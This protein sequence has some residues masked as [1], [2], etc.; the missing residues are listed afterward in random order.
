MSMVNSEDRRGP[1]SSLL[2]NNNVLGFLF[3][4]PAAVFLVCFLTYPLGLGVWLGFTDTRIGRDG[5]FIGLENYQFLMDDSVF[6][7]SVF[8]TILY[9]SV[10]SVLKFALG[11]W[12]AM[13]LNQHLPFKSFFRAIV[14]LPWVVPT[15]LSALAFW[16]IY[17]SQ[18]SIISWS[19]MKL[20]LISGPINFLG[21]PIN[22]RISV[23]VANVWRGIPFV[24]IS[25]LAGL[26]TIPASLQE[27]ASLDGATSWQ[28][29]RYVTLPMLTP[30]IAVV[31]TF[32]VLFT[33]T[34]FQLIYVL[35]KGGPVNATHLMATLSFQRGI[36]GGQL[37]EGA[38]IAVA[39]V[40]FLLGAIMFSFFG[41]QRRKWQQGGQD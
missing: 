7:L 37:G 17:D 5:I 41:L 39:M 34:D 21:D 40:P 15:V 16:W 3:M 10:A 22:A 26:Q 27:A 13:L 29:F 1:I 9:T 28:R 18:F 11:L 8:N 6:W 23:I 14:L 35:T 24:A 4:L 20:G 2:Q 30:I 36:P 19:L 25:L 33:F 38:A 32:S 31:M 12:L